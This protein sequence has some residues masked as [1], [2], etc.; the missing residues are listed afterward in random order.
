MDD[1]V[2]VEFSDESFGESDDSSLDPDYVP[3]P[4]EATSDS[5]DSVETEEES[6]EENLKRATLRRSVRQ[7]KLR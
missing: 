1:F 3:V 2:K 5:E 6:E 7:K 4:R